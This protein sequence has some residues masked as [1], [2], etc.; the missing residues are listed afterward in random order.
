MQYASRILQNVIYK[1]Q[2]A[3]CHM[4]NAIC[5]MKSAIGDMQFAMYSLQHAKCK[6]Q[7][8]IC[9]KEVS[10]YNLKDVVTVTC[11]LRNAKSKI[12]SLR[13]N[14]QKATSNMQSTNCNCN[15]KNL[16]NAIC[17]R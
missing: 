3:K 17:K 15:I 13:C 5:K 7:N 12:K 9:K 16:Q 8:T 2:F 11:N 6:I 1:I 4:Q 14:L 10:K